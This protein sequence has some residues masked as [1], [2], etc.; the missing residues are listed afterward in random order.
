MRLRGTPLSVPHLGIQNF[1][2]L[3][4]FAG[5]PAAA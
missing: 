3:G 2:H 1:P 4:S 5:L